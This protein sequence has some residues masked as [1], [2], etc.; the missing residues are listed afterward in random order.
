MSLWGRI[1]EA[2]VEQFEAIEEPEDVSG[3]LG[4][5]LRCILGILRSTGEAI[6]GGCDT[7]FLLQYIAARGAEDGSDL[8]L[9]GTVLVADVE[10]ARHLVTRRGRGALALA[11]SMWT[12]LPETPVIVPTREGHGYVLCGIRGKEWSKG[13]LTLSKIRSLSCR[14]D[15]DEMLD[16]Y[17]PNDVVPLELPN[18]IPDELAMC[19]TPSRPTQC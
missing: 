4:T 18:E 13:P 19:A 10:E 12:E 15:D 9:I 6:L 17:L 5:C 16:F 14:D 1:G 3:C 8:D 2:T 11:A 7:P